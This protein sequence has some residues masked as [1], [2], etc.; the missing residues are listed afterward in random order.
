MSQRTLIDARNTACPGP[1]MELI[2]GIKLIEIGDEIEL[3]SNDAGTAGD[4]PTWCSKIGH[5]LVSKKKVDDHW[6]MVVS[7]AK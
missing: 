6:S 1:L 3:L 2:A 4:V 5:K 7:R